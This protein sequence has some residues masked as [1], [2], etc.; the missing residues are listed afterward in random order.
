MRIRVSWPFCYNLESDILLV[1]A[2]FHSLAAGR[3][4][5]ANSI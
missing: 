5:L 3:G 1:R 2:K 4:C